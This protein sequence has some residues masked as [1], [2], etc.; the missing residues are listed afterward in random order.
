LA[1]SRYFSNRIDTYPLEKTEKEKEIKIVK[2]ILHNNQYDTTTVNI[3]SSD[4]KNKEKGTE[5]ENLVDNIHYKRVTFQYY[6]KEVKYITKLF[7]GTNARIAY[8][9]SM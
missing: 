9:T 3:S 6:A 4:K 2:N 5:G 8:K 1:A 7:T